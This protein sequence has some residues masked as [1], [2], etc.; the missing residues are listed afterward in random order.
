M[1]KVFASDLDNTLIHSY[2]VAQSDDICVETK[3]GKK[4]SYMTPSAHILLAKVIKEI[5]FV[6]I[7]TRSLEQYNRIAFFDNYF[8]KYALV[9][10]GGILLVDNKLDQ[11]WYDESL[12]IQSTVKSELEICMEVLK[13]DRNIIFEIRNVD[14]LMVFT[15]SS[16]AE[17]TMTAL[18][19]VVDESNVAILNHKEKV[20]A[21]PK[22]LNKGTALQRLRKKFNSTTII[23]AGDSAFDLPMLAV[24]DIAI[25][26][27]ENFLTAGTNKIITWDQQKSFSDFVLQTVQKYIVSV[28]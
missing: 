21:V 12:K 18:K 1:K 6:P 5:P 4:L 2:K 22:S 13:R 9:S 27:Q 17:Q 3:D 19:N 7:T 15:K 16:N 28:K 24:A 26:P 14:G 23:S 20:Y 11:E 25:T 8:P 10:N